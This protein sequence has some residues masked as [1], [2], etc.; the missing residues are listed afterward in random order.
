MIDRLNFPIKRFFSNLFKINPA[1]CCLQ[2]ILLKIQRH[3]KV[4]I[5]KIEKYISDI[6]YFKNVVFYF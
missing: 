3:R 2:R 6:F 4:K 5:K 1:I